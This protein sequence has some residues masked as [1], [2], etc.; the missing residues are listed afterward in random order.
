VVAVSFWRSVR[1][2]DSPMPAPIHAA[3]VLAHP[4]DRDDD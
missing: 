4:P 2:P 3:F 1:G